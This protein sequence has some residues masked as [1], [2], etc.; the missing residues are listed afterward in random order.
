MFDVS[1]PGVKLILAEA[2]ATVVLDALTDYVVAL[3]KTLDA[4]PD[5]STPEMSAAYLVKQRA[6]AI[7][8]QLRTLLA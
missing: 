3:E 7:S 8:E 2:D 4:A 5:D 1:T 6:Y